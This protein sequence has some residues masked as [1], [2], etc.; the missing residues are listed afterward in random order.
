[1]KKIII[2][3][4]IALFYSAISLAQMPQSTSGCHCFQERTFNPKKKFAADN[5]LLTTSFN[6]F[7]AV[8]FNLSKSQ[9]VMMKMKG[10]IDPDILLIALYIAREGAVDL[11]VVLAVLANGGTWKQV[12]ESKS[13]QGTSQAKKVFTAIIATGEKHAEAAEIVIDDLLKS[14]FAMQDADIVELRKE[15][16]NGRELV[17]VNILSRN[18]KRDSSPSEILIMH[19]KLGMSWGEISHYF[20]FTPK[21]TGRLLGGQARELIQ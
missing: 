6:S 10:G 9:I 17:L 2:T 20:G 11:D 12:V 19:S 3:V 1:M 16:A 14:Y 7:I 18:T 5:Y 8:N 15:H 4:F 13:I 21:E